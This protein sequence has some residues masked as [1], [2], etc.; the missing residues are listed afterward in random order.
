M[1]RQLDPCRDTPP[2]TPPTPLPG[3]APPAPSLTP[4]EQRRLTELRANQE[5]SGKALRAVMELLKEKGF[6]TQKELLAR[7]K[8]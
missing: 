4:E 2:P 5:R 7:L 6:T 3:R 8:L 1:R